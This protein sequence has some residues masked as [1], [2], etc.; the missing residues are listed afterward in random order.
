MGF[1]ALSGRAGGLL[2][3]RALENV[4]EFG[5]V[6]RKLTSLQQYAPDERT[7]T[8]AGSGRRGFSECR[9]TIHRQQDRHAA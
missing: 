3:G 2:F 4:I 6:L 7:K 1:F 8:I 9:Q 5:F